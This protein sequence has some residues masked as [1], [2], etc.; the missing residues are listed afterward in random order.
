MVEP[1]IIYATERIYMQLINGVVLSIGSKSG[2]GRNN[3]P[4]TKF[5][6]QFSDGKNWSTFDATI[7]GKATSLQG[8]PATIIGQVTQRGEF[9][10]YDLLD[11]GP[12]G[13]LSLPEGVENT[14]NGFTPQNIPGVS[15]A[16]NKRRS[17]EQVRWESA[18]IAAT[19][20]PNDMDNI[21]LDY[22][23][24]LAKRIYFAMETPPTNPQEP[25][26]P[27]EVASTVP[28]TNV[29]ADRDW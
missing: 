8:Q 14:T 19:N 9:T 15:D 11:I 20:L 21:T 5:D 23:L 16:D 26:T 10:N 1:D 18:I 2:T 29:G 24:D 22:V 17:K 13:S 6:I 25:T 27:E 4:Y 3:R 7:A 28:N 12:E